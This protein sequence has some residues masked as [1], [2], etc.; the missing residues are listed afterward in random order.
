MSRAISSA[1]HFPSNAAPAEFPLPGTSAL[2]E[3][4]EL[5]DEAVTDVCSH[6]LSAT[7]TRPSPSSDFCTPHASDCLYKC[8]FVTTRNFLK[9][10]AAPNCEVASDWQVPTSW[11]FQPGTIQLA[12]SFELTDPWLLRENLLP[13]MGCGDGWSRW[14]GAPIYM[15][16]AFVTGMA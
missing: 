2:G 11:Q 15:A 12:T 7:T 4:V 13:H 5:P 10:R 6:S 9:T 14:L 3:K 16:V 1:T 8:N